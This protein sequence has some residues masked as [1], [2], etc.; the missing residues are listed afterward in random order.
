MPYADTMNDHGW[1]LNLDG[2]TPTGDTISKHISQYIVASPEI[3]KKVIVAS[4]PWLDESNTDWKDH[5]IKN[6][7]NWL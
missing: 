1:N 2:P 4:T 6:W 7:G 5:Q 3:K